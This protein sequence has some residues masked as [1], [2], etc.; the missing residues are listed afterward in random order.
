[1]KKFAET[2]DQK[3]TPL[4]HKS[5]QDQGVDQA[6]LDATLQTAVEYSSQKAIVTLIKAG[7]KNIKECL[8][9]ALICPELCESAV[10]LLMFI[11]FNE[12]D[13]ELVKLLLTDRA[14][15][16]Q[17]DDGSLSPELLQRAYFPE[18]WNRSL[19]SDTLSKLR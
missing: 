5:E 11:A 15:D 4:C 7:A 9:V 3:L 16:E 8:Q 19:P 18:E 2:D 10:L 1:M 6:C 14:K 12:N 17:I 13:E